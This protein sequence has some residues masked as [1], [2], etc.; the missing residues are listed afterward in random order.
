MRGALALGIALLVLTT[1]AAPHAHGTTLGTHACIACVA[2]GATEAHAETP[3]LAP[4]PLSE[5][6]PRLRPAGSPVAGAPLGA[7]PGQS[8]PHA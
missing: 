2:A 6:A 4:R 7:V 5:P 1:A 8:P 3:D